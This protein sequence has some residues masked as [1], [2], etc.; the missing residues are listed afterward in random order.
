[1]RILEYGCRGVSEIRDVMCLPTPAAGLRALL[2]NYAPSN[3]LPTVDKVLNAI[4]INVLQWSIIGFAIAFGLGGR[5]IASDIVASLKI[6]KLYNK[7]A[8]VEYDNVKGVLKEIG[9]FDSLVY[10][11]T[12][13]INIPNSSLARKIIRR[14][15]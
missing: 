12:G 9:W 10:T 6:R 2:C 3:T 8:E 4:I 5:H 1:M 15:I 13:V 11:D 14:K 7:G